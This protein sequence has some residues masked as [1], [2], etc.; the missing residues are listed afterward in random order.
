MSKRKRSLLNDNSSDVAL[1]LSLVIAHMTQHRAR[2][3]V[4]TMDDILKSFILVKDLRNIVAMFNPNP[5]N[6]DVLNMI[7]EIQHIE[8]R[9][10]DA[11]AKQ[12]W[13][14]LS[15]LTPITSLFSV[16]SWAIL[17]KEFL[18]P[19]FRKSP[20]EWIIDHSLIRVANVLHWSSFQLSSNASPS[21]EEIVI[22]SNEIVAAYVLLRMTARVTNQSI[23]GFH[24]PVFGTLSSKISQAAE[25]CSHITSFRPRQDLYTT[26]SEFIWQMTHF[27]N[28]VSS[29][30]A[31]K[32]TLSEHKI[33]ANDMTNIIND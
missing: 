31:N 32:Q 3:A 2:E 25:N 21:D 16:G 8:R 9:C 33:V 23:I 7:L 22:L 10:S 15:D 28:E 17:D 5:D 26:L 1:S 30:L 12:D 6:S 29:H 20:G 4:K 14:A 11:K 19:V 18:N 13:S 24:Y 27:S